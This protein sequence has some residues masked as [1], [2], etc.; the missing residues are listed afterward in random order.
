MGPEYAVQAHVDLKGKLLLPI[1]WGLFSL[2]FHPWTE[3]VE[4]IIKAAKQLNVDL[5]LPSPGQTYDVG[6]GSYISKWWEA[7]K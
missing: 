1:H 4:L 7:I 2:A 3:P 5:L 6:K